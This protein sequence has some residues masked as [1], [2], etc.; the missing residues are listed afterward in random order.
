MAIDNHST[1]NLMINSPPSSFENSDF[2]P[3]AFSL[4]KR[5]LSTNKPKNLC[6]NAPHLSAT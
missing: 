6:V 4:I 3:T 5:G 1:I 2:G